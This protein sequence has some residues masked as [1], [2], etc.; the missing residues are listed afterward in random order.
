MLHVSQ[1]YSPLFSQYLYHRLRVSLLICPVLAKHL[2][3]IYA[4]FDQT[5]IISFPNPRLSYLFSLFKLQTQTT[6]QY[7]LICIFKPNSRVYFIVRQL[8]LRLNVD[9]D[10]IVT[11]DCVVRSVSCFNRDFGSYLFS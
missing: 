10:V 3:A 4:L 11:S 9:L 5:Y 1:R 7:L 8:I 2:F 6:E